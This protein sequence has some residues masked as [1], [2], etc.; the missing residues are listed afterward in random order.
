LSQRKCTV[1]VCRYRVV[2]RRT[3]TDDLSKMTKLVIKFCSV[4]VAIAAIVFAQ[5]GP[6]DWQVRTGLGWQT[7]HVLAYFV[8]T[9][10]ACLVWPR[11]FV[12]G[13]AF[14]A[15]SVLLE[16]LQDLTPDR[17][18]NFQAGLFGAGGALAAALLVELFTR[19][20]RWGTPLKTVK[21]A[22][23]LAV[24]AFA[25]LSLV[26]W[27]L[28]PHTGAPESFEHL[29]AYALAGALLTVGYGKRIQP[30][31]IVLSL[32][33]YAAILEIAQIWVPGRDPKFIDFAASSAGAL[34]G[35]ALVWIG[36]RVTR[37]TGTGEMVSANTERGKT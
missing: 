6:G 2:Y 34:I 3:Q 1:S 17:H 37:P 14:M 19:A 25:F 13:P 24:V 10:I 12:V 11:P 15:A 18:A 35:S 7:E 5:L 26:P 23:A 27:Q 9:S 4:A 36:L 30:S 29:A 31:I 32:F 8:V 21:I 28:R 22:G 16:A 33:L 20:W